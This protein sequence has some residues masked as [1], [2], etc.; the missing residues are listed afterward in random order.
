MILGSLYLRFY[1]AS[2]LTVHWRRSP[3]RED[4]DWT[5]GQIITTL[6]CLYGLIWIADCLIR[7][8]QGTITAAGG[9]TLLN[10]CILLSLGDHTFT[11]Y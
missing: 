7:P 9:F 4:W 3:F 2:L 1:N 6:L 8:R 5:P 10:L 11:R